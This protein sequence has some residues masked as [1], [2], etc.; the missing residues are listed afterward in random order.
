MLNAG[1]HVMNLLFPR[2]CAGCDKPDDVLC[3]A[4]RALFDCRVSQPLEKAWMER[5]FACGW[6]RGA[7]RQAVLAWKD[8]G[9][10]E[11]DRPFADALCGLAEHAGVIGA[12]GKDLSCDR[13]LIVPAPSSRASMRQ[14]GRRHM[15][16]LSKSLASYLRGRTGIRV[17]ACAAL[18]SRGVAGKSVETKGT[19]QRSQRLKGRIA[20]HPGISLQDTAVI[21]VDDIVTSGTTMRRCVDALSAQGALVLTLLALAYTPAGRPGQDDDHLSSEM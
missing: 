19:A 14:R 18:E 12:L 3:D 5:W 2:G 9:D 15:M 21:V 17:Q 13:L 4:C 6:Y 11:C 16:P 10:E 8:H 20:V 1:A 7:A